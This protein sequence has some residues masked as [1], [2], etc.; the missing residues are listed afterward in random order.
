MVGEVSQALKKIRKEC[1][2]SELSTQDPEDADEIQL[3]MKVK[4]QTMSFQ[5]MISYINSFKL[6]CL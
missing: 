5:M 1:S 4:P 6:K 3:I 2:E